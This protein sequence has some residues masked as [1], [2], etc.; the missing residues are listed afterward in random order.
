MGKTEKPLFAK[1]VIQRRKQMGF[2]TALVFSEAINIPYPTIRNIEAGLSEGNPRTKQALAKFFGCTVADIYGAEPLQIQT[3]F[4]PKELMAVLGKAAANAYESPLKAEIEALKT[5][6]A[7]L[8]LDN[9]N[10]AR[11]LNQKYDQLSDEA[12]LIRVYKAAPAI[13]QTYAWYY[14]T[15]I[16]DGITHLEFARQKVA[17]SE[18]ERA[19]QLIT[20]EK[21]KT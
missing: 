20:S 7:R 10:M 1:N 9:E 11:D 14:L 16:W 15:G 5:E 21:V 19:L 6:V 8:K 17:E 12:K 18:R 4:V 2:K 3:T 13:F